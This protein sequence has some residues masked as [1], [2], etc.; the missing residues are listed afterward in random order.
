MSEIIYWKDFFDSCAPNYM[1]NCFVK[2]TSAE[3]DF[4]VDVLSLPQLGRILDIG[5]GIGQKAI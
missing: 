1:D 5:C 3:V 4:I 2:N